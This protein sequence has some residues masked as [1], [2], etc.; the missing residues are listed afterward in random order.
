M[1]LTSNALQEV[2]ERERKI[3]QMRESESTAAGRSAKEGE[4][5]EWERQQEVD[6][7]DEESRCR[8]I[9]RQIFLA[10]ERHLVFAKNNTRTRFPLF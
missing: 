5:A 4:R 7:A 10:L 6:R 8:R 3:S 9:P 2:T 1:V